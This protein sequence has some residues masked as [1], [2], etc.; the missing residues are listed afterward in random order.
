MRRVAVGRTIHRLSE[1]LSRTYD[2]TQQALL[3][4]KTFLLAC[5]EEV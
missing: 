2:R 3:E 1:V 4:K 5:S